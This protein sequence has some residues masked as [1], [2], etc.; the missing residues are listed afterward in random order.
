MPKIQSKHGSATVCHEGERFDADENGIF[1]VP[2]HLAQILESHGFVTVEETDNFPI[3]R[4]R[5]RKTADAPSE[6]DE[7]EQP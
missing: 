2:T 5:P 1:D 4:G 7:V 6:A 3:R